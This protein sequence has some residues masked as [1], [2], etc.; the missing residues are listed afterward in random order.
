MQQISLQTS[1]T[2]FH[3]NPPKSFEDKTCR[4]AGITCPLCAHFMHFVHRMHN[5]ELAMYIISVFSSC[6]GGGGKVPLIL[7]LH[8]CRSVSAENAAWVCLGATPANFKM[9]LRVLFQPSK[10]KW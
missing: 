6:H 7:N 10:F 5:D 3:H 8:T 1:G 9:K 2:K 4:Q